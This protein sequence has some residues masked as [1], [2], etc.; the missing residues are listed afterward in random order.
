MQMTWQR[1]TLGGSPF[2]RCD[3]II[4]TLGRMSSR[5]HSPGPPLYTFAAINLSRGKLLRCS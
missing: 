3:D 4:C 2:L 5:Q 1:C